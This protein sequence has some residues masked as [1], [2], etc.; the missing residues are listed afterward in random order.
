VGA[1]PFFLQFRVFFFSRCLCFLSFLCRTGKQGRHTFL[2]VSLVLWDPSLHG[3]Q[4]M[5][6][7]PSLLSCPFLNLCVFSIN[8]PSAVVWLFKKRAVLLVLMSCKG[9]GWLFN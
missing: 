8:K 5:S 1:P 3:F 9:V 7:W 4:R 6:L 2:C